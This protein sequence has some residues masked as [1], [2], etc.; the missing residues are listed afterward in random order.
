MS[1]LYLS[2]NAVHFTEDSRE[3]GALSTTDGSDNGGQ[4]TLLDGHVDIVDEGLGFLS[5][6]SGRSGGRGIVLLGPF[7]RSVG[8]ANGIGIDRVGIRGNWGSLRGHQEGVDAAPGSSSDSAGTKGRTENAALG[9]KLGQTY[10][11]S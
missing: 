6:L 8:D 2:G 11:R 9:E 5:I 1:V 7:E 4:A 10:L 3:E